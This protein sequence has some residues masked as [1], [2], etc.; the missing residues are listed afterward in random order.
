MR[1]S[2]RGGSPQS[3]LY[4]QG[5]YSSCTNHLITGTALF[6]SPAAAA[7]GR[8]AELKA[9]NRKVAIYMAS[10]VTAVLGISY[11]AVPLYKVFCQ[12]RVTKTVAPGGGVTGGVAYTYVCTDHFGTKQRW[13]S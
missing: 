4:T 5:I 8:A 7:A 2:G 1:K 9:R 11:A 10:V 3:K 13:H 6:M 12:V